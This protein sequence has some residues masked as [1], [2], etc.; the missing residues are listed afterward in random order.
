MNGFSFDSNILI[1]ALAGYGPANVEI[2]RAFDQHGRGWISR[3][4][5]I[6][7]LSKGNPSACRQSELLLSGFQIDEIDVDI[8]A[9]AAAL[10]RERARLKSADAIILASAQL[11]GRTL[12]T[13]N[14]RD[15]PVDTPGVRIPYLV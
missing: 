8:S 13:R 15:F 12:I 9:R 11:R 5:W 4:V 1:D 10:R 6:E 7:V 14:I 3:M 2:Q